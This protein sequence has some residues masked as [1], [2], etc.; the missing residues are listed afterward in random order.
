VSNRRFAV[1]ALLVALSLAALPGAAAAQG[2]SEVRVPGSFKTETQL[3]P[4]GSRCNAY[5]TYVWGHIPG[6]ISYRVQAT[7]TIT[8]SYDDTVEPG[9]DAGL[10]D[11]LPPVGKNMQ[12]TRM[13]AS[14]GPAP[15]PGDLNGGRWT[16]KVTRTSARSRSAATRQPARAMRASRR[17]WAPCST[18]TARPPV[19]SQSRS[20]AR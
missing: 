14:F 20:R 17:S 8:G 5:L 19:G 12:R 4:D 16:V 11:G 9:F 18:P 6:A 1:T 15:C 13:N 3:S 2:S 7:D 10:A